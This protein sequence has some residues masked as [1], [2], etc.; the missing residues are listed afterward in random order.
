MRVALR[1]TSFRSLHAKPHNAAA[2][3]NPKLVNSVLTNYYYPK[4]ELMVLVQAGKEFSVESKR[5][6]AR[7]GWQKEGL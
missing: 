3:L 2:I 6:R 5:G 1:N 4:K 7:N